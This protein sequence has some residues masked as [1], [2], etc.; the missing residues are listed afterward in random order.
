[1]SPHRGRIPEPAPA[2]QPIYATRALPL[3]TALAPV[4]NSSSTW[5]LRLRQIYAATRHLRLR[6]PSLPT[7]GRPQCRCN[8]ADVQQL[9]TDIRA[10]SVPAPLST[11]PRPPPSH[12]S[13]QLRPYQCS[14]K[15]P[16]LRRIRWPRGGLFGRYFVYVV[17]GLLLLA[18]YVYELAVGEAPLP[19]WGVLLGLGVNVAGSRL[20]SAANP[21]DC[22]RSPAPRSRGFS[23]SALGPEPQPRAAVSN[24]ARART[25][26]AWRGFLSMQE[27]PSA[28]SALGL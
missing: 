25:N 22:L 23:S 16:Q 4:T 1:M 17:S 26:E 18:G 14:R 24:E 11:H 10:S 28:H 5:R 13:P 2:N 8:T 19:G 12:A 7:I 3:A 9:S 20:P 15:S 21:F 27:S 6:A